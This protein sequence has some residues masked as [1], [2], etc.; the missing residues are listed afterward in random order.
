MF[1]C[2]YVNLYIKTATVSAY[3]FFL[4]DVPI[5]M[6]EP[7]SKEETNILNVSRLSVVLVWLWKP[8]VQDD[9][10]SLQWGYH[11]TCYGEKSCRNIH[12]YHCPLIRQI[13]PVDGKVWWCYLHLQQK[14]LSCVHKTVWRHSL[15]SKD[16]M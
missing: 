3:N 16:Y 4:I 1:Y 8:P 11:Q 14:Y 15:S 10:C 12:T 9:S 13:A 2:I 5:K 6:F 7:V